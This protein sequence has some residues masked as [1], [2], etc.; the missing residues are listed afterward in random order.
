MSKIE[1]YKSQLQQLGFNARV[2]QGGNAPV[3]GQLQACISNV[4][5]DIACDHK[6]VGQFIRANLSR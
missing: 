3:G 5:V 6:S 1:S 4:W 2:L